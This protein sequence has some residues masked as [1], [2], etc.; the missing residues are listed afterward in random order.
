MPASNNNETVTSAATTMPAPPIV[1]HA[2]KHQPEAVPINNENNPNGNGNEHSKTGSREQQQDEEEQVV[3]EQHQHQQQDDE[4]HQHQ[5]QGDEQQ[6]KHQHQQ[7]DDEQHQHQDQDDHGDVDR[8]QSLKRRREETEQHFFASIK[9]ARVE[10]HSLV[11][12]TFNVLEQELAEYR[13]EMEQLEVN[14]DHAVHMRED[15]HQNHTKL[16]G[17]VGDILG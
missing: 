2:V 8:V 9:Q 16:L 5:Q 3:L 17:C 15:A 10:A 14:L 6:I 1:E 11:E 4:Q 12:E 7:H 13:K